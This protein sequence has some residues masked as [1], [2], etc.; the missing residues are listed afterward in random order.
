MTKTELI[1][2]IGELVLTEIDDVN[3]IVYSEGEEPA[4]FTVL[5]E[6]GKKFV[7]NTEEKAE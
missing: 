7:V 4:S 5:F 1:T 6:N 3:D 2:L